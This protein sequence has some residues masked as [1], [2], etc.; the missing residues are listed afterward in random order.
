MLTCNLFI[1]E[2]LREAMHSYRINEIP[3]GAIITDGNKIIS[4]AHNEKCTTNICINHAEIICIREACIKVKSWN[5]SKLSM[6][7]T[8]EPCLMCAGAIFESR[9]KNLYIGVSNP[10]NG[11]F[12]SNY[13]KNML[14]LNVYWINNKK[15]EFILN[16]FFQKIRKRSI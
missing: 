9:L 2:A 4:R 15:C 12:S 6:Y 3:V 10:I 5:L 8:L 13:H 14:P 7:V 11:F 1:T 16:R